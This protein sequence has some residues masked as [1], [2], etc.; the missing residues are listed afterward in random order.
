MKQKIKIILVNRTSLAISSALVI[1]I[2]TL[3]C[4]PGIA[5]AAAVTICYD[6][7]SHNNQIISGDSAKQ[8]CTAQGFAL[9]QSG[10]T[11]QYPV[12]VDQNTNTMQAVSDV[13][14]CASA[15][16]TGIP[17]GQH[18]PVLEDGSG[19]TGSSDLA[20]TKDEVETKDKAAGCQ[21]AKVDPSDKNPNPNL[22][23]CLAANP[24][25]TMIN[26]AI[27]FLAIGV[28]VV[29]IIMVIVGGIQ[30]ASSGG[31]PNTVMEAKKKFANAALAL[32]AFV[33]L[34]A[35]LQWLVPGGMF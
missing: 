24:I 19:G 21:D 5:H 15:G 14:Q 17:A 28:G 4:L 8:A 33:F 7:Q 35:F 34:Y 20:N 16:F 29:V 30:Y 12:C 6:P 10:S 26:N 9:V 27:N 23:K 1:L 22:K 13:G 32:L 3:L 2:A 18:I 11:A 31:N 25:I